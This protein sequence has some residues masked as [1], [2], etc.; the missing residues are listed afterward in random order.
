MPRSTVGAGDSTL[1]GFLFDDGAP[2]ER[3]RRAVSW[4]SA[5]KPANTTIPGPADINDEGVVVVPNPTCPALTDLPAKLGS[6]SR[7]QRP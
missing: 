6:G 2:E 1:A 5:A 7:A 4:G 3:L